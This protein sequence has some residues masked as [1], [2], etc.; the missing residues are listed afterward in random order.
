SPATV[1]LAS[2]INPTNCSFI[3][4]GDCVNSIPDAIADVHAAFLASAIPFDVS[5]A[6]LKIAGCDATGACSGTGFPTN[7]APDPAN[8]TG[9]V[10]GFPNDVTVNNVIGKVDVHLNE[11]NTIGGMYFYGNNNGTVEDFPE[12]Q[13][14]WLSLIHTRAQVLGGNW[15]W[16]KNARWVN[17]A[18]LGYNRLYQPTYPADHNVSAQSAY[19][20]NTGVPSG[21]L[22]GGL[23]RI[24]FFGEF[25]TLGG[26]KW[27]KLQGPDTRVQFVDQISYTRGAHAFKFGGEIHHDGVSGGAFGN[28]KGSI[29]FGGGAAWSLNTGTVVSSSLED[30]FAGAPTNAS[31]L[32][33]DPRR[34]LSNWA[35]ALFAQDDWRL[36]R[37]VTV[38]LGLR[39]ELNTVLKDAHNLLGNF[40]PN[41]GLVQVGK[42]ISAPFNGNH[43]NFAPR[44]G[45]A[46]DVS[47]KGLTVVRAG[48][49]LMYEAVNWETYLA[50]AN[51]FGLTSI[52]TGATL[53]GL[54]G[55]GTILVG[56]LS[57][58]PATPWDN[59]PVFVDISPANLHC[60]DAAAGGA[61]A[62]MSVDRGI[63]TPRVWNW[64]LS[65]QQAFGPNL[66]LEVAYVGNHGDKLIGIHDINQPPVGAGWPAAAIT[67][68]IQSGYTDQVNC[69][70][71]STGAEET[72]RPFYPQ[73]PYLTNIFQMGNIYRSD[74]N[75]LQTT[76]TARNYHGLSMVLG[77]T[78]SHSLDDVGANWD[79]GYGLG[80]PQDSYNPGREYASSDFDIRHRFTWSLTY[81]LPGRK[82]FAQLLEGWQFNSIVSLS[83]AQPWG[84][85]DLGTDAAG[86]G[87]LPVSPPAS[88]PNRWNFFGKPGDFKPQFG[89]IPQ[90]GGASNA[91]CAQKAL[92]LDGGTAGPATAALNLYG[93]YANG[94]S[95]MLP[96]ALGTFGT[97]GRNLFRD[98]GFRNW[99]LSVAK[100]WK[101]TET[102]GA[103]FRAEFF[104]VLNHPNFANPY[105][106]QNGFGLNDPSAPPFGCLCATP[107]VAAA[108]P[109]IGSGGSR[110]VQL[111]LK[112]TF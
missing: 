103:Q 105:G 9:V 61:C 50:F 7:N 93:C 58:A 99:D 109:V 91:V 24:G 71:D 18:R 49:G 81:A 108:N 22:Y 74:Y 25:Q 53:N 28:A 92:A 95:M 12:L 45:F 2:T 96:P 17:E 102:F 63:R 4:A 15:I 36:T 10:N 51:S 82:S 78:Y 98:T 80:L 57:P 111:G 60:N 3:P 14:K 29:N 54:P 27:P 8:P 47:G 106:G 88:S 101:F 97:M 43:A 26:F 13:S 59:G 11:R 44:F 87:P 66:S 37:N 40:D 100:N 31:V 68:C 19:G 23:P 107:D 38:N 20:L 32:S 83:G 41:A 65:L 69:A 67:A 16:V 34:Q 35:Y 62:I 90:F 104:N 48:G 46:W 84:P 52:P 21:P 73:F 42:Q 39:Y 64:N 76:L 33:G 56:N 55:P 75:G 1:S 86:T 77:Y 72:S 112:L 110:A 94:N 79:F 89:G 5:P 30:F 70:P 85:I 6:S